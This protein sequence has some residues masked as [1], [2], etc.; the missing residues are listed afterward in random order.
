MTIKVIQTFKCQFVENV[1]VLMKLKI[2][3]L[4]ILTVIF[5]L[6]SIDKVLSRR[7][8]RGGEKRT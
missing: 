2:K 4:I 3:L 6:N 1:L 7:L 8:A 5:M